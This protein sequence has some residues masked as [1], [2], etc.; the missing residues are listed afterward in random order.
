MSAPRATAKRRTE[1]RSRRRS[2]RPCCAITA[3][4]GPPAVL[5][6]SLINPPD[7][8]DLDEDVSLAA[9]VARMGRRSLLLDWGAARERADLDVGGHVEKLLVP[10]LTAAR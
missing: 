7:V 8:L 9:A 10:L 2:D 6:P 1:R 3:A 5:V 4:S